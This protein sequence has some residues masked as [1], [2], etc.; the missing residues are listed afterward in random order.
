MLAGTA[1]ENARRGNATTV[2]LR[3]GTRDREWVPELAEAV[4][5]R[6]LPDDIGDGKDLRHV[7]ATLRAAL[8]N[9]SQPTVLHTHFSDF[10]LASLLVGSAR[11][12]TAIVWHEHGRPSDRPAARARSLVKY[13]ALARPVNRILCVSS[14]I[15][16][17]VRAR[18]APE[19]AVLTFPNAID[20]DRFVTIDPQARSDARSALGIDAGTRVV[21]H[22]SWDW[23]RKGGDL[24]LAAARILNRPDLCWITVPGPPGAEPHQG[25]EGL[26]GIRA[27]PSRGD[28]RM[29]YASADVFLS[30]SRSEGMPYAMLEA[31]ARGLPVVASDLP[32]HHPA[33]RGLPAGYIT[34]LDPVV[35]A[36]AIS[37]AI[38][39]SPED[40]KRHA[41]LARARVRSE[42]SL[43][44]WA[45]R[46]ADI[47]DA[48]QA[49]RP[50]HGR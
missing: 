28:V 34:A 31:L 21:L 23:E 38:D 30:C 36:A 5:L 1:R 18:R 27:L 26:S 43:A 24:L 47:Y 3:A 44:D 41:E 48:S 37:R 13:G 6:W 14:E 33:L 50:G 40:L 19:R 29:L 20:L 32:G 8:P 11:R 7:V 22:F 17:D 46:L 49:S 4:R 42:Y 45:T 15:A 10:D 35:I 9:S 25:L 2:W 39:L 12:Q 16:Q